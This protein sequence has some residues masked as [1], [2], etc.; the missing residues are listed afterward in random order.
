MEMDRILILTHNLPD[1]DAIGSALALTAGLRQKGKTVRATWSGDLSSCY[2]ILTDAYEEE[3]FE[4]EH[5]I[6]VDLAGVHL[7][8][9]DTKKYGEMIVRERAAWRERHANS[10][11][12]RSWQD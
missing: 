6:S 10:A 9:A 12:R 4:P 1:G 3:D 2:S 7:L 5:I 8:P 11:A